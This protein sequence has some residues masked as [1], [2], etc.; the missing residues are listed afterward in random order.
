MAEE[1]YYATALGGLAALSGDGKTDFS[2]EMPQASLYDPKNGAAFNLG[3]GVH[4]NDWVA[5]QGNYI[6]NHND[7]ILAE[8]QGQT[9][10]ERQRGVRQNAVDV[11]GLLFFRP[12]R[13]KI[14]PYLSVGLGAVH[15][16]VADVISNWA[17]VARRCGD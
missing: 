4:L 5:I 15:I 1:K 14:R 10:Q 12:R 7:V 16:R 2:G 8:I 11:D 6:W 13:S 9:F 3:A 17:G